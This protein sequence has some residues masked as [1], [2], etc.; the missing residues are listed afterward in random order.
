VLAVLVGVPFVLDNGGSD[1][2]QTLTA[3]APLQSSAE[4]Y[5]GDLGDLSDRDRIR[6]RL[7]GAAPS[8]AFA[9]A[10]AE[11]GPSAAAGAPAPSPMVG[12]APVSGGSAGASNELAATTT[13][14]PPAAGLTAGRQRGGSASKAAPESATDSAAD[15]SFSSDQSSGD[16]AAIDTCV[17]ALLNGPAR[18]GRLT[19]AGTGTY[20]GRPAIVA[21]FELSGGTE[22]FITDRSGCAVLDRFSL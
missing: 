21:S 1:R 20:R 14:P 9:S 5:I 18:G 13:M 3:Q 17:T 6:L 16:R 10:P 12:V 11:P 15:Q 2:D 19:R 4:T 22:A 7:S 8:D